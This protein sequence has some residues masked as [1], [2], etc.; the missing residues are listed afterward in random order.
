MST[1]SLICKETPNHEYI[2]IYCHND[3]YLN[4]VGKYLV[5]NYS[6]RVKV[7]ALLALG[8]ISTL[9]AEVAPPPG[10]EHSYDHPAF[11]VCVAY[12]RDRGEEMSH[13]RIFTLANYAESW[14]E[15][16]YVFGLDNKWRYFDGVPDDENEKPKEIREEWAEGY[17]DK[18][19]PESE[20]AYGDTD[21][22]FDSIFTVW[23][24]F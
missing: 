5:K 16:M 10:V 18:P 11:N 24:L 20:T 17:Y 13:A 12:H 22:D 1:R 3:G 2:G 23:K 8:D 9:R 15:Y 6:T 7:D 4:G 19:A 14:C 21:Q